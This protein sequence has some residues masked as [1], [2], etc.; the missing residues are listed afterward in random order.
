MFQFCSQASNY[1]NAYDDDSLSVVSFHWGGR[2]LVIETDGDFYNAELVL[3]TLH[4]GMIASTVNV[5]GGG[6]DDRGN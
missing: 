3:S 6:S 2:P 1:S 4:Y 5:G